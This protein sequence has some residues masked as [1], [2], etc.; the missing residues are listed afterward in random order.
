MKFDVMKTWP[1]CC[2]QYANIMPYPRRRREE[3][4]AEKETERERER[5]IQRNDASRL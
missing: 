4:E 1:R 2:N 3:I 5:E